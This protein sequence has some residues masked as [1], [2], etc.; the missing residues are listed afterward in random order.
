MVKFS[1]LTKLGAATLLSAAVGIA[2][3]GERVSDFSLVDAEGRFFQLSRHANQDAVVLF[4]QDESRDMRK[5]AKDIAALAEQFAGQKVEFL[6]LDSTGRADKAELRKAAEKAGISLRVLIDDTQLVAEELGLSRAL[7]VAILDPAAKELV[8]R[9]ALN[10]R[11]AEGKKARRASEH[12]VADALQAMMAGEEVTAQFA[13]NGD[14]IDF[15]SGELMSVSYANDV[16][17]IL[18]QRC[19]T[20]HQEGGIAPFAMSS[21]QMVQ[22]WS[23]MIRETLIT[24]R[25]PPGQIDVEYTNDFHGVN[26][27]TV[28]ETQKLV[29]W[30]DSGAKNEGNT[31]P[32]A[33]L[34]T[35]VVK[36]GHGEPDMIVDIPPQTIPASGTVEYRNLVLPLD[37]PE[38]KWVKAVEFVAG[39][40]TVL[41]HII[42]W[43]QAPDNG[44]GRGGA[45]GIL[46]QG[47]GLG[48]YAPGNAINTYPEG[49]GFPLEQG[50]GLILQMHYTTS[51]KETVD[52][53]QIGIHFWD[54]EPER[55][56]LGGSAADLEID[57]APFEANHEMV[58]TKKF[59]KDSYL[60]MVGP[61]MHY[62][63][64]D[65]NFKLVYPDGR[66][67][68]V[69]NVP[70]YQFNWQKTY[71]FKEPKYMP[72]GTEMV[73]RATFDNSDM[74]PFNPDPS[75]EI[76]W[77][78]QTWQ[79][80]FFGFFRYVEADEGE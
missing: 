27:I 8:Y 75:A 53:S 13:S 76:S 55:P 35:E 74:N 9:G 64:Y 19:V 54:E 11:F 31:D 78:E 5:A 65:A 28:E 16:A 38:D 58:A 47:I 14:A 33:E 4:A 63:G 40:T 50:S 72:A 41:H 24:K 22:G 39:D 30:I 6:M 61:H 67:E 3:A 51:G 2:N 57:I 18:E 70:N 20:C 10:D 59:R 21:H 68:E 46:N 15:A 66:E 34:Q 71:D 25:M 77:G 60:T 49:A 52:A 45:F 26:H 37:L 43:A 12:Y 69:L 29:H 79:E 56:I 44:S 62:R 1:T 73:F 23:P 48:A 7:E 17:P 42:A 36:W 80:M 32:L